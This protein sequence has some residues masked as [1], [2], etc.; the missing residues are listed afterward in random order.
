MVNVI[1]LESCA[2][3]SAFVTPSKW[4]VRANK[5]WN[6]IYS[7][8]R[9]SEITAFR[10]YFFFWWIRRHNGIKSLEQFYDGPLQ[11]AASHGIYER[12]DKINDKGWRITMA[13]IQF[14]VSTVYGSG[15]QFLWHRNLIPRIS[16]ETVERCEFPFQILRSVM[17]CD[18]P[19]QRKVSF[20]VRFMNEIDY[21]WNVYSMTKIPLFYNST[22]YYWC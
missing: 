16:C 18:C 5:T 4:N 12:I 22:F 13:S 20:S 17:I 11:P 1:T 9:R 15:C 3:C 10:F 2:L 8:K 21:S 19:P 6:T 7:Y 14:A